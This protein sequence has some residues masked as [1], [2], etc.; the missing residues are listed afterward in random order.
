MRRS[1]AVGVI[2]DLIR[3]GIGVRRGGSG[4]ANPI[5]VRFVANITGTNLNWANGSAAPNLYDG[6]IG[7]NLTFYQQVAGQSQTA[8]LVGMYDL[9]S[10][11]VITRVRYRYGSVNG[12]SRINS[13][14]IIEASN[15]GS[16]WVTAWTGGNPAVEAGT[17][18]FLWNAERDFSTITTTPYRYWRVGVRDI[19]VDGNPDARL[20]DFRVYTAR[21]IVTP[22]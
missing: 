10:A 13:T 8:H 17:G 1:S 22:T 9:G 7:E 11:Q 18:T 6:S 3:T 21:G 12:N 14:E 5:L 19:F 4:G 15:D 20:S 2:S 16:T